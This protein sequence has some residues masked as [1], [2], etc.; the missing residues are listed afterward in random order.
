MNATGRSHSIQVRSGTGYPGSETG[1]TPIRLAT[2]RASWRAE[3]SRQ[4]SPCAAYIS[5]NG[6]ST[7]AGMALASR[8]SISLDHLMVRQFW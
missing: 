7:I 8:L 2:A 5:S 4:N 3:R 1:L 6:R